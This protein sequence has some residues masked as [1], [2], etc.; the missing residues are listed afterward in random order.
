M[1]R[2]SATIRFVGFQVP[3]ARAEAR[4]SSSAAVETPSPV[5]NRSQARPDRSVSDPLI[6][7][8]PRCDP[9]APAVVY[10]YLQ[11]PAP[12]PDGAKPM[13]MPGT[14]TRAI[15]APVYDSLNVTGQLQ[16]G[17]QMDDRD[18]QLLALSAQLRAALQTVERLSDGPK[19]T[20]DER[21]IVAVSA[22]ATERHQPRTRADV[23]RFA[24]AVE[25]GDEAW[26]VI[27]SV[28]GENRTD[29]TYCSVLPGEV[30]KVLGI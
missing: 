28:P 22:M 4:A 17:E 12:P 27:R 14:M 9:R 2:A 5:T 21:R 26:L 10:R 16:T 23:L 7:I 15:A 25:A 13:T 6:C 29:A 11:V 30:R 1:R 19:M 3:S 8:T 24:A 20:D 18:Q